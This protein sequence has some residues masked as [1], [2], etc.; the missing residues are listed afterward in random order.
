VVSARA[1]RLSLLGRCF[2]VGVLLWAVG[3]A[4][5]AGAPG[6][7]AA[8]VALAVAGT[9]NALEDASMFTL[10]PRQLGTRAAAGGLGALE[11]VVLAGV[12]TGSLA[13][14]LLVDV[15]DV[16]ATLLVIGGAVALAAL[17]Y[18]A[19][20]TSLDRAVPPPSPD[21]ELLRALPAFS[22]LPVVVVE[23]LAEALEV[24]H[25]RA[26]QSVVAEG[27]PGDRFRVVREG[28]AE[29]TVHG[30]PRRALGPGDG[31]GE[32]ALL[33][34]IPRTASVTATTDLTTLSLAR[35]AFLDA[36]ATTSASRTRAESVAAATMADDPEPGG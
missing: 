28:C 13:T 8:L 4:L 1:L 30:H 27:A 22:V 15:L 9:G 14:P 36:L 2:V 35:E 23:D 17:G 16:R 32:I 5:L 19:A 12:G 25:F 3:T 26:G 24:E 33:R 21:V 10:L 11:L 29:V 7:A 34:D 6:L 20:F 18:A 31:F